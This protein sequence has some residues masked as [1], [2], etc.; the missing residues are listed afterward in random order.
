MRRTSSRDENGFV[1]Y[2]VGS[3]L[4]AEHPVDLLAPRGQHDDRD[5]PRLGTGPH[6]LQDVD[7]G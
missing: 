7:S 6:L 3:Q 2:V 5:H 1:T 4:E